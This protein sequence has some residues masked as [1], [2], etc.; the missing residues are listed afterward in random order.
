MFLGLVRRWI[1]GFFIKGCQWAIWVRRTVF[2]S[3]MSIHFFIWRAHFFISSSIW[4]PVSIHFFTSFAVFRFGKDLDPESFSHKNVASTMIGPPYRWPS[5]P[6]T[7]WYGRRHS[8]PTE[9]CWLYWE[10]MQNRS[11]SI[12][13]FDIISPWFTKLIPKDNMYRSTDTKFTIWLYSIAMENGRSIDDFPSYT[14]PFMRDFQ[15]FS[16]SLCYITRW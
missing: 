9:N 3:K 7:M 11:N 13:Q 8:S 1:I 4:E 14:P 2:Y 15:R 16:S 5:F 10:S 6:A 12:Y